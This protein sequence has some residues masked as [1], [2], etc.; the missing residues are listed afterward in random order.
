M[1]NRDPLIAAVDVEN[2]VL[3]VGADEANVGWRDTGSEMDLGLVG[4]IVARTVDDRVLAVAARDIIGVVPW[5]AFQHIVAEPAGN[6]VVAGP[7]DDR[8]VPWTAEHVDAGNAGR[9]PGRQD[10]V[11][12][13]VD[14]G[15]PLEDAE[16]ALLAAIGE[17]QFADD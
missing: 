16:I 2:D 7:G 17:A 8:V 14:V 12:V 10:D 13:A 3:A 5:S 6:D 4:G 11:V 1:Y 9:P 15:D